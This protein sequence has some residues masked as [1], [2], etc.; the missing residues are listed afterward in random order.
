MSTAI[1]VMVAVV[2]SLISTAVVLVIPMMAS[3]LI[4][5]RLGIDP[6]T[7]LPWLLVMSFLNILLV[8]PLID[9]L[10]EVAVRLRR[11]LP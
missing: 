9:W 1:N 4:F 5:V 7:A 6:I 3:E 11:S 2:F 8:R 10:V